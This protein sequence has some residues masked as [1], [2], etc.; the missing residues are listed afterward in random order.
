MVA[1]AQRYCWPSLVCLLLVVIS[2]SLLAGCANTVNTNLPLAT[3]D[4][5]VPG[6]DAQQGKQAIT[7]YG[8]GSCHI[9]AGVAGADGLVGPPLTG[10]ADRAYIAGMLSNTP[11]NMV[12]W[13]VDPQ[14]IVPGNAMPILGVSQNEARDISAYLYTLHQR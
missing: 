1:K 7:R 6:G 14:A 2:A 3:M 9:I 13:I 11:N 4:Q 10:I 8:C 5:T 12:T